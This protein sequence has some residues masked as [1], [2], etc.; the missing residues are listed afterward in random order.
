M[1]SAGLCTGPLPSFGRPVD[2][3]AYFSISIARKTTSR[4]AIERG[5][6]FIDTAS[7]YGHGEGQRRVGLAL[8]DGWREKVYLQTKDWKAQGR[9]AYILLG[10]LITFTERLFY[11]GGTAGFTRCWQL[12]VDAAI[13]AQEISALGKIPH[14][15][16]VR[17]PTP[18][19]IAKP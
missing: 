11:K 10:Q 19:E 1:R 8:A 15:R 3:R 12:A 13:A 7:E 4:Q 18:N 9:I 5:I 2:K 6:D 14:E 17:A 16:R